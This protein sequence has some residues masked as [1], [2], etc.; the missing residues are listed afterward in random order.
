M[1]IVTWNIACLPRYLNIFSNPMN[2]IA[3]ILNKLSKYDADII[4]L[5]EVFDKNIREI[6]IKYFKDINKDNIDKDN[7]S[8]TNATP[9]CFFYCN[10][11]NIFFN[12]GLLTITKYNIINKENYIFNNACGE[13]CLVYKG[14]HYLLLHDI[15]NN[16]YI[17]LLN[18]H[19]NADPN[20]RLKDNPIT[21]RE[22]QIKKILKT[23]NNNSF[24]YNLFCGDMNVKYENPNRLLLLDS[25]KTQYKYVNTNDDKIK[26]F[27]EDQLDYIIYYGSRELIKY[28]L[29]NELIVNESDHHLLFCELEY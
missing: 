3:S 23:I 11:S 2:R 10:N 8:Q 20:I 5:Q 27:D 14:Y 19:M 6:I 4:C 28:E 9:Y 15:K 1:K 21:I 25:L 22:N 26:T 13:D 7:V 24:S 29:K 17:S 16:K 12:D 18:T